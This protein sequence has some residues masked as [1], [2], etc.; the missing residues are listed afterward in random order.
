M[1]WRDITYENGY[2]EDDYTWERSGFYI[3]LRREFYYRGL[4]KNN[5]EYDITRE[6]MTRFIK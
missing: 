6:E 4:V 3:E 2:D 5:V 1:K